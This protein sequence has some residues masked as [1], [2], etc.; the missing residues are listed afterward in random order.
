MKRKHVLRIVLTLIVTGLALAYIFWKIDIGETAAHPRER[1]SLLLR[2]F[3]RDRVPHGAADG[4]ALE[5]AAAREGHPRQLAVADARLLRLL[6]GQPDASH[7]GRRRRRPH[8]RDGEAASGQRRACRGVDRAGTGARR[9]RDAD[10]GRDRHRARVRELRHRH[11]PLGR[12]RVRRRDRAGGNRPLLQARPAA[13]APVRARPEEAVGRAARPRRL[14]GD[15]L[16][17]ATTRSC[18]SS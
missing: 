3:R 9:R 11:L 16:R 17:T 13:A 10:P 8:L 4:L 6:L 1:R 12:G 14:R 15:P 7:L 18:S 2:A 5:A